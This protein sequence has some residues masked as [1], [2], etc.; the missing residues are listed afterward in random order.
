M[1]FKNWLFI[2]V[3]ITEIQKSPKIC[4]LVDTLYNMLT[5]LFNKAY[6]VLN[7]NMT[8]LFKS[9]N[10]HLW[11]KIKINKNLHSSILL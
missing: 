1:Q 11:Q 8:I 4:S 6:L 10:G 7:S 9:E 5:D 3:Y 2:N